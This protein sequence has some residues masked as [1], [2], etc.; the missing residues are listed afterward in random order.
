MV[1]IL[2]AGSELRMISL[3]QVLWIWQRF[4]LSL[5]GVALALAQAPG[6]AIAEEQQHQNDCPVQSD[7]GLPEQAIA[8]DIYQ[9]PNVLFRDD[10]GERWRVDL[11]AASHDIAAH[12]AFIGFW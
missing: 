5:S 4:V 12:A 7:R 3:G 10:P 2:P 11:I 1:A 6:T 8:I 9:S